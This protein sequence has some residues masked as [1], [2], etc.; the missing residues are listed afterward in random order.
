MPL[1][2]PGNFK[3]YQVCVSDRAWQ[4]FPAYKR[5]TFLDG[6]K[7]DLIVEQPM[8]RIRPRRCLRLRIETAA[9]LE[10]IA[11]LNKIRNPWLPTSTG[12]RYGTGKIGLAIEAIGQH[13]ATKGRT[14]SAE[15]S[16]KKVKENE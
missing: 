3:I 2:K 16:V 8:P 6:L 10:V 7:P 4:A 11:T 13:L 1:A 12:T 14:F 15:S 9:K 5:G